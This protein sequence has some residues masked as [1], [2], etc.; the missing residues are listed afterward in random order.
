MAYLLLV[1]GF[2]NAPILYS[3]LKLEERAFGGCHTV[4]EATGASNSR[5]ETCRLVQEAEEK[6]KTISADVAKVDAEAKQALQQARLTVSN[7]AAKGM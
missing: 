4:L 6:L 2:I 7:V 1:L 5:H 3:I